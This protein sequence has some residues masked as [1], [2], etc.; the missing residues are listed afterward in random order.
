MVNILTQFMV[1]NESYTRIFFGNMV[2]SALWSISIWSRRGPYIRDPVY[3]ITTVH[4]ALII[5]WPWK[6]RRPPSQ[7]YKDKR[8]RFSGSLSE[9]QA[10]P[11][12]AQICLIRKL[13][14][15]DFSAVTGFKGLEEYQTMSAFLA[16]PESRQ[17]TAMLIKK[18]VGGERLSWWKGSLEL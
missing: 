14:F 15:F 5:S 17:L 2:I 4:I 8:H 3:F 13:A 10:F 7:Y 11:E 9:W 12:F 18:I 16:F 6:V 1:P